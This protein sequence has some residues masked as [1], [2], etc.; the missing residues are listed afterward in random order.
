[1]NKVKNFQSS[2]N[3]VFGIKAQKIREQ[4]KNYIETL[5][6]ANLEEKNSN[7]SYLKD[8]DNNTYKVIKENRFMI[9]IEF[10]NELRVD[11][12]DENKN[13]TG[14]ITKDYISFIKDAINEVENLTQYCIDKINLFR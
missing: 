3:T 4:Y 2:S 7:I 5:Y 12:L 14:T 8:Y 11:D 13:V 1:M 6:S 10:Q 9:E